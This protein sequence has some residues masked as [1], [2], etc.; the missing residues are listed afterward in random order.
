MRLTAGEIAFYIACLLLYL[1]NAKAALFIF[2]I[3]FFFARIV[4]MLGNWAQHAFV[5]PDNPEE[6]TINCI[7][8]C[9]VQRKSGEPYKTKPRKKNNTNPVQKPTPTLA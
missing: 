2:I 9:R 4:M 8:S 1:F 3:P 7:N 6:N 5:D